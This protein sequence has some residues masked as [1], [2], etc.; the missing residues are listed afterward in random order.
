MEGNNSG[1]KWSQAAVK[2][3]ILALITVA[4]NT[5]SYIT[6]NQFLN[7]LS[8]IVRTVAS[9]WLL[10]FF[11]KQYH[12]STGQK[13]FSFGLAV[14]LF[15]S[16]ICAFYDAAALQW[17]FP[18]I[19]DQVTEAMNQSLSMIPSDQQGL[20]DSM[21]D[22]YPVIAFFS[23]FIKDFIIGLIVAAIAN[24][25]IKGKDDIFNGEGKD[26]TDELA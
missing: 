11:M 7:I 8:F 22:H 25:S 12:T 18:D 3:L 1:N 20:V 14:V 13:P 24:S 16:F 10:I 23:S 26:T 2:G 9:I 5:V 4:C 17:L 19:M 6:Q 21:M 15:S